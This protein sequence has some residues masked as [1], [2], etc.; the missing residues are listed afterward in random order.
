MLAWPTPTTLK[1]LRDFLGLTSYYRK[2]FR[3]YRKISQPLIM[4]LRKDQF[5]WSTES[6]VTFNFL[7]QAMASAPIL[8]LPNF[9]K[10]FIVEYDTLGVGLKVVL[11]QERHPIA[12]SS[13]TLFLKNFGMSTYKKE[14][15]AMV[16]VVRK[17]HSY[18]AWHHFKI[19]TNHLSLKYKLEQSIS[20]YAQQCFFFN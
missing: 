20:A 12:V 7:K 3:D 4:L 6:K 16:F 17:W 1:S 9:S 15:M 19:R 2:F 18:L 5:Q 8:A 11:M 14:L 10:E 13:Q